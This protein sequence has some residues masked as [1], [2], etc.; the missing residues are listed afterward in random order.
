MPKIPTPAGPTSSAIALTRSRPMMLL[1][2]CAP[3][4]IDDERKI[5]P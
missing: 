4:M 3:P 5:W 2:I 1:M